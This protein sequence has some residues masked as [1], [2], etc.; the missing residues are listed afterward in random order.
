MAQ[1]DEHA[2]IELDEQQLK[3]VAKASEGA[4]LELNR[5]GCPVHGSAT[6]SLIYEVKI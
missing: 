3:N 1:N 4:K 2:A 6:S 5:G